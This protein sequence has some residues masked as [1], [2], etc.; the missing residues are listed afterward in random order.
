MK[1]KVNKEEYE[2]LL[3]RVKE[4]E[5]YKEEDWKRFIWLEERLQERMEDFFK[6]K[7]M[8]V[9]IKRDRHEVV[10]EVQK[11]IDDLFEEEHE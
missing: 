2:D 9:V 1:V 10:A 7:C 4:L 8:T 3:K 11:A 6:H 5:E